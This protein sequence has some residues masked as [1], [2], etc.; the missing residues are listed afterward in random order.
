MVM[1]HA[2]NKVNMTMVCAALLQRTEQLPL[3]EHEYEILLIVL[4]YVS[5]MLLLHKGRRLLLTDRSY[6][7]SSNTVH[8]SM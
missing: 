2:L 5:T 7:T 8:S 4:W 6:T 1:Y 3:D